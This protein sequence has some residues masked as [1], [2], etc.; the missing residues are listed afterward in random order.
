M[1]WINFD[2]QI[3][4]DEFVEDNNL[5]QT[6]NLNNQPDGQMNMFNPN[7]LSIDDLRRY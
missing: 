1:F 5:Q 6:N 2:K 3:Q 4:V 7:Q